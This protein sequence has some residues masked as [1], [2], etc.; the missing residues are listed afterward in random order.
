MAWLAE[1]DADGSKSISYDEL[2]AF[3]AQE[4]FEGC[5]EQMR[6]LYDWAKFH[7]DEG[8]LER[9]FKKVD[10][11]GSGEIEF[12]EFREMLNIELDEGSL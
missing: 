12:E 2:E 7:Y 5:S 9:I 3:A 8:N 4:E 10:A 11:D 6:L 1:F